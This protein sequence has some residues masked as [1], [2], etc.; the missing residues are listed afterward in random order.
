LDPRRPRT[1]YVNLIEA[2]FSGRGQAGHAYVIQECGLRHLDSRLNY[3]GFSV[4]KK[5]TDDLKASFRSSLNRTCFDNNPMDDDEVTGRLMPERWTVAIIK[6]LNT[7]L[8][9]H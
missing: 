2:T 6:A 8:G 7:V 1:S 3:A 4:I 9:V 5:R